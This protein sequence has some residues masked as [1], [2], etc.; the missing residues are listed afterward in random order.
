MLLNVHS[1]YSLRY[2][3]IG[4]EPLTDLLINA[5][6]TA[7]VLTDINNTTGSLE[8][9]KLCMGKGIKGM[10]G[11]EFR[12]GDTLLYIG[13]AR[14]AEGFREMN[15]L[16]TQ[17]NLT[18]T[19]LPET[20]PAF[21]DV[22]VIYPFGIRQVHELNENEYIGV[23]PKHLNKIWGSKDYSR[24]VVWQPVTFA[25]KKDFRLH[26]QLR[27]INNNILLSQLLPHQAANREDLLCTRDALLQALDNPDVTVIEG[28][29]VVTEA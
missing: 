26:C 5:G 18:E 20:A 22:Y 8:F 2:G 3:T 7:A 4:I 19:H 13:I 12:N 24:Y 29:K 10:A 9:L 23:K 28:R 25:N 11:V 16:L 15:E 1:Y 14:G 27:A 6:Y 17:C 21:N